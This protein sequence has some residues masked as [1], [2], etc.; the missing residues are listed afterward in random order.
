M[1]WRLLRNSNFWTCHITECSLVGCFFSLTFAD[2]FHTFGCVKKLRFLFR[3]ASVDSYS[4]HLPQTWNFC[5][6][7]W[8][9]WKFNFVFGF[10]T[11]SH[12][13]KGTSFLFGYRF[14]WVVPWARMMILHFQEMLCSSAVDFL[15]R[16]KTNARHG[17]ILIARRVIKNSGNWLYIIFTSSDLSRAPPCISFRR[18]LLVWPQS[19]FG[20]INEVNIDNQ[21]LLRR[22]GSAYVH[23]LVSWRASKVK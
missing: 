22:A 20:R 4:L 23:S 18:S 15:S 14:K 3:G 19:W 13:W 16:H 6:Y 1:A 7:L 11:V 2:R 21:G 5:W 9:F 12:H 10:S 8:E 17:W